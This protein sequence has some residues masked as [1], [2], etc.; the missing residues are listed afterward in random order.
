MLY[1][2]ELRVPQGVVLADDR[3]G[4]KSPRATAYTPPQAPLERSNYLKIEVLIA[5]RKMT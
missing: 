3:M 1:P 4:V 2:V 5:A